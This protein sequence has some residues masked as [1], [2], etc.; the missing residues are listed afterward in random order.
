MR[1]RVRSHGEEREIADVAGLDAAHR[2]DAGHGVAGI[3]VHAGD[4]RHRDV[5]HAAPPRERRMGDRDLRR[6]LGEVRDVA[7]LLHGAA[8]REDA[9]ACE[10]E[11]LG[12][13]GR[14]LERRDHR[15]GQ[16]PRAGRSGRHD[17][18]QVQP[19]LG[20]DGHER[21]RLA[22]DTERDR[23]RRMQMRDGARRRPG[24]VDRRVHQH[25]LGRHV[26][27]GAGDLPPGEIDG[28]EVRR[29]R[30]AER[31]TARRD[32]KEIGC[33]EA[34][35]EIAPRR[36]D[37]AAIP[38]HPAEARDLLAQPCFGRVDHRCTGGCHQAALP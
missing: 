10:E 13:R 37:E 28:H 38:G 34:G 5:E 19:L 23:V 21:D 22:A 36:G 32:E 27:V 16:L 8:P 7:R 9:V 12:V 33:P 14:G 29:L 15:I 17:G 24:R 1:A 4:V 11:H 31:H 6:V 2:V 26:A 3:H 20:R 18:C 30:V 35:R 25:F